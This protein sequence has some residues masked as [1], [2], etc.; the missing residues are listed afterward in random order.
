[1]LAYPGRMKRLGLFGLVALT[2]GCSAEAEHAARV[3]E[4]PVD[5]ANPTLLT[6][7]V[8]PSQV[9]AFAYLEAC[10]ATSWTW[11]LHEA[12][13]TP[14]HLHA[15]R[16]GMPLLT[17]RLGAEAATRAVLVQV[18]DLFKMRDPNLELALKASEVDSEA[19]AHV[20]FGQVTHGIPVVGAELAAHYDAEGRLTSIDANY[21][22]G[23]TDVALEPTLSETAGRALALADVVA[24]TD[25]SAYPTPQVAEG[26]LVVFALGHIPAT[27][28]YVYT[29]R[30]IAGTEPAIWVLTVDA[31]TGVVIHR[32]NSL[33]TLVASGKGVLGNAQTFEV[34][35]KGTGYQMSED[36]RAVQVRTYTAGAKKIGPAEGAKL[37]TSTSLTS[38][39]TDAF[40]GAAVDA[41]T[42]A[43]V[44][45]DYYKKVHGRNAIDGVGGAMLS[46]V[47][48]D[49]AFENAFWDGTGMTYGDGGELLRPLSA[50]LDVVGHEF[51]HGVTERTSGLRYE[52]QSGAL[53]E[54]ISDIFGVFI[55][56]SVAPDP[57]KNWVMGENI[58]KGAFV[59]R[60]FKA[61]EVGQQPSNMKNFVNW[62]LSKDAGGVHINSG[63]INNAAFLMTVGGINPVSKIELKFGIG[64]EKSE[65]VWYRAN[66]KYF[67]EMTNFAQAAQGVMQSAKDLSFTTNEQNIVDCAWKA[68]GVVK[69]TCAELVDPNPPAVPATS[70]TPVDAGRT[71]SPR[72][73][74]E[75]GVATPRSTE[76]D[77]GL[78]VSKPSE[79]PSTLTQADAATATFEAP[80][81]ASSE[82]CGMAVSRRTAARP[83]AWLVA[84]AL[85]VVLRRRRRV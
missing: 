29:V 8:T 16:N 67:L 54:A 79:T 62:P 23:I 60:D 33:Q 52:N 71:A 69:G 65:K 49:V 22:P 4:G 2:V 25:A 17:G 24:R 35:A 78:A 31:T 7:G 61:P 81:P 64:W 27:L 51:T 21:I 38:W 15:S 82:G 41:H 39:D 73:A 53:N 43:G 85:G 44:V 72:A 10:T 9:R 26:K 18:R 32:Y 5:E 56:H 37:V 66:T 1:M 46:T 14:M 75:A 68:T 50:A 84:A 28:A 57:K 11:R 13:A 42:Y 74:A 58:A 34:S 36:S 30:A 80:S 83:F 59:L 6:E 77:A 45:F 76:E 47:H 48:F 12:Q 19:M 20:R 40:A 63:I 3:A 55:E 70:V